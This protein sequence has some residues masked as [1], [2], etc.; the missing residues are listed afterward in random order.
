[1]VNNGKLKIRCSLLRAKQDGSSRIKD[2]VIDVRIGRERSQRHLS[3][4]ADGAPQK[5]DEVGDGFTRICGRHQ[6]S[7]ARAA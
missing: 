6:A 3:D 1:M 4:A 5:F 7:S 2:D